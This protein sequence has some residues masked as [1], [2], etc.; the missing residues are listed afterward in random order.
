VGH[1][2]IIKMNYIRWWK[3]GEGKGGLNDWP[4]DRRGR[5]KDWLREKPKRYIRAFKFMSCLYGSAGCACVGGPTSGFMKCQAA[6]FILIFST[7]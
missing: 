6:V 3:L 1:L 2:T 4:Q 5:Q 7:V